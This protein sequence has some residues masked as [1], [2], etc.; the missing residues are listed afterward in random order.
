M[1]RLLDKAADGLWFVTK[2]LCL[3]FLLQLLVSFTMHQMAKGCV[4][5]SLSYKSCMIDGKNVS[6]TLTSLAWF[7]IL[8]FAVIGILTFVRLFIVGIK[9]LFFREKHNKKNRVDPVYPAW[10]RALSAKEHQG[11]ALNLGHQTCCA[12]PLCIT[13]IAIDKPSKVN[14]LKFAVQS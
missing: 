1:K 14:A 4:D 8:T 5:V 12:C 6:L 10:A 3:L 7:G 9:N 11:Q 13:R 2:L